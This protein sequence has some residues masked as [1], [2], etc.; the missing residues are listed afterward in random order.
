MNNFQYAIAK[1]AWEAYRLNHGSSFDGLLDY[2]KS[3]WLKVARAVLEAF[4]REDMGI[5]YAYVEEAL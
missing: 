5:I 2:E 1:A 4:E 3:M